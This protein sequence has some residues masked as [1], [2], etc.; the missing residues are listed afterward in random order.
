M[1]RKEFFLLLFF[2]C[3]STYPRVI[4][5]NIHTR[6]HSLFLS[7]TIVYRFD[8]ISFSHGRCTRRL[9]RLNVF[10]LRNPRCIPFISSFIVAKSLTNSFLA[11]RKEICDGV[12]ERKRRNPS[13][14][15]L[16]VKR[17]LTFFRCVFLAVIFHPASSFVCDFL[18]L[19]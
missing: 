12:L 10:Q 8:V 18:P 15:E 16:F 19:K 3:T 14:L 1:Y 11:R 17:I 2:F 4:S 13:P 9:N 7:R 5:L 6:T